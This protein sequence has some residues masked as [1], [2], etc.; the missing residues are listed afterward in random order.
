[1]AKRSIEMSIEEKDKLK[2]G[3]RPFQTEDSYEAGDFEDEFEDEFE[4]D[5]E[6][7]EAGADGRPDEEHEAIESRGMW[8]VPEALCE[9][10]DSSINCYG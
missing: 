8:T 4:S 5:D 3:E 6:I 1:M 10:V 9:S 2:N 7:F